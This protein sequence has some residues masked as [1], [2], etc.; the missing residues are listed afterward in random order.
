MPEVEP[1]LDRT[2]IRGKR[3]RE[4]PDLR[5]KEQME[6]GGE[7]DRDFKKGKATI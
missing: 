1:K 5:G 6:R 7:A 3:K 4:E 2:R